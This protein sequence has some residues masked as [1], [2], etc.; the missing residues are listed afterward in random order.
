M[1]RL[2]PCTG[3]LRCDWYN[4][5]AA[6][7]SVAGFRIGRC[8]ILGKCDLVAQ[9]VGHRI[10]ESENNI[11]FRENMAVISIGYYLTFPVPWYTPDLVIFVTEDSV[12]VP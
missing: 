9:L 5:G 6:T 3:V 11:C 10:T 1:G 12:I 7:S 4:T 8:A 2:R